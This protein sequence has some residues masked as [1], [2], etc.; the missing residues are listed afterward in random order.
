MAGAASSA[1]SSSSGSSWPKVVD[2]RKQRTPVPPFPLD[3]LP[4]LFRAYVEDVSDLLQCP[5][6]YVAIPLLVEAAT[7]IGQSIRLAPLRHNDWSERPCLWGA[8]VGTPGT[9]KSPAAEIALKTIHDLQKELYDKYKAAHRQWKAQVQQAKTRGLSPPPEPQL[10]SILVHE[11]TVEAL[12]KIQEGN[13]RGVLLYRDELSGWL[14]TFNKYRN[15]VGDDR[16]FYLQ[17]WSGGSYR[18]DR[19]SRETIYVENLY[20]SIFGSIQP[21]VLKEAFRQGDQDGL[22]ARFGMI[23]WPDPIPLTKVVDRQPDI[24]IR[25]DVDLALRSLRSASSGS[26][27]KPKIIRFSEDASELYKEWCLR[28]GKK[29]EHD[30]PLVAHL[31]KYPGLFARLALVHWSLRVA[32]GEIEC[33]ANEVDL[34][35]AKAVG[36]FLDKYLEPHARKVYDQIE[37][38]QGAEGAR[39]IAQWIIDEAI[40]EFTPRDIRMKCW[41][42]LKDQESVIQ[43]LDYLANVGGW[44]VVEKRPSGPQGGRPSTRCMVNPNVWKL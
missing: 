22:N 38:S 39:R 4:R 17:C 25:H 7:L 3:F 18:V 5:S 11:T 28:Q 27:N 35:T 44:I 34:H 21:G 13:P 29:I 16:Q 14:K 24:Q 42:G 36:D 9:K 12:I 1:T 2:I 26:N 23:V 19:L 43:A 15:R 6:D 31:A 37:E 32:S 40:K 33:V 20:L 8:I 10:E 30:S 41:S